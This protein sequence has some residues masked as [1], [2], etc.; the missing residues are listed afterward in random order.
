M[1]YVNL[2]FLL[3]YSITI[4]KL[5]CLIR[6]QLVKMLLDDN[7]EFRQLVEYAF[8]RNSQTLSKI[9]TVG[10]GQKTR[11]TKQINIYPQNLAAFS[12]NILNSHNFLQLIELDVQEDFLNQSIMIYSS[13]KQIKFISC[14]KSLMNMFTI[15]V[16][17][18]SQSIHKHRIYLIYIKLII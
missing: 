15:F 13:I 11:K 14:L 7:F 5:E 1:Y 12:I 4:F 9:F 6:L 18:Q 17:S 8:R 16:R 2:Q 10:L 3:D